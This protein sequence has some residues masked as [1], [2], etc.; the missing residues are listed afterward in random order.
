MIALLFLLLGITCAVAFLVDS[1]L[2]SNVTRFRALVLPLGLLVLGLAGWRPR[3]LAAICL[4]LASVYTFSPYVAAAT[5]LGDT[6]AARAEFWRPALAFLRAD[7]NPNYRVDVVPTFDNWEAYYLPRAG[8]ALARGWY[9]QLDL[10]RNPALYRATLTGPDYREWLRANVRYVMLPRVKLDRVA[11]TAQAELLRSGRSGLVEVAY[12]SDWT[13]YELTDAT[14]IL[15]G[16]AAAGL[17]GLEHERI[18]GWTRAPGSYLVRASYTPYWAVSG[19]ACV[20][21]A[22]GGM[23]RLVMRRAGP[24]EPPCREPEGSRWTVS[25]WSRRRLPASEARVAVPVTKGEEPRASRRLARLWRERRR[26]PRRVRRLRPARPTGGHGAGPRHE[27][28][29]EP[30]G[31][32]R[33]RRDLTRRRPGG[34]PVQ[35]FRTCGGCR[36]QDLAYEAQIAAKE[37]R[38]GMRSSVSAGCPTSAPSRSSRPWRRSTT[39]T[40]SSTPHRDSRRA[41]ARL[42]PSGAVGRGA[43][44]RALLADDQPRHGR[45]GRCARLGTVRGV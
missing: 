3:W 37:P 32:D 31:G 4:V 38:S 2:G 5:G 18:A 14:P 43:R 7:P 1:P 16:P 39:A 29:A 8:F 24:F 26:A 28:E 34:G 33:A 45:Q 9:R 13:V 25:G 44:R 12:L 21:P 22:A 27:S 17:T 35:A 20:E 19:D 40:S 6:R 11:A 10:V 15:T 42:P 41:C 36:F 30:R 23:T